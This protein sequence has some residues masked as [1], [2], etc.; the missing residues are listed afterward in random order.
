MEER[1][2]VP[3]SVKSQV[4]SRIE[5][6]FHLHEPWV[7]DS[8][9][10]G[11]SKRS[12]FKI[13]IMAHKMNR[14]SKIE[15]CLNMRGRLELRLHNHLKPTNLENSWS[16]DSRYTIIHLV[17][18]LVWSAVTWWA[19]HTTAINRTVK[20]DKS[21]RPQAKDPR[22]KSIPGQGRRAGGLWQRCRSCSRHC[23]RCWTQRPEQCFHQGRPTCWPKTEPKKIYQPQITTNRPEMWSP[24]I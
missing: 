24:Q 3:V 20:L 21:F 7:S 16:I 9:S 2:V 23:L 22:G 4:R 19:S 13:K 12:N 8:R 10:L 11:E 14:K 17:L 1:V 6:C 15:I 5:G 18:T